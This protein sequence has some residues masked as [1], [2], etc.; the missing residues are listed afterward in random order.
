[1]KK[2]NEEQSMQNKYTQTTSTSPPCLLAGGGRG[3]TH[4]YSYTTTH[5]LFRRGYTGHEHLEPFGIINMNGRLYDPNTASF[6]SPDPYVVDP[7]NTQAFNRYSYCLN[8][9]LMYTDPSGEWS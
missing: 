6:F 1:L 2:Q 4:T 5:T 7:S 9:P 8:N 3:G